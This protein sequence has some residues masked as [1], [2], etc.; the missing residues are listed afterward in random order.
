[1]VL[2]FLLLLCWY[3][4]LDLLCLGGF[5]IDDCIA[6]DVMLSAALGITHSHDS[7]QSH[8]WKKAV[9][10]A[11]LSVFREDFTTSQSK[12]HETW[13]YSWAPTS[14][15]K[16]CTDRVIFSKLSSMP[17]FHVLL[18]GTSK[19]YNYNCFCGCWVEKNI[20]STLR[21]GY[22]WDLMELKELECWQIWLYKG[23]S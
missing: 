5:G 11:L 3:G 6:E 21:N 9:T 1:M 20:R 12:T 13:S 23:I 18:T 8:I 15:A 22:I 4:S 7:R 14:T 17:W 2:H 19:F 16:K 10:V